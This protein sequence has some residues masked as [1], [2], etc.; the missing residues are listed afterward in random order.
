MSVESGTRDTQGVKEPILKQDNIHRELYIYLGLLPSP[1]ALPL[2]PPSNPKPPIRQSVMRCT[3]H[4]L[5]KS[6][7][8]LNLQ[9]LL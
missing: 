3:C 1:D 5:C 4:S 7:T 6:H 8:T 9:I 2:Y